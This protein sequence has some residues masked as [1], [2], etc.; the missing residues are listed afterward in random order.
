L[1][2]SSAT[3]NGFV[4]GLTLSVSSP[5]GSESDTIEVQQSLTASPEILASSYTPYRLR[6]LITNN[7]GFVA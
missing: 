1:S 6:G 3:P 4:E 5:E 2:K 7:N